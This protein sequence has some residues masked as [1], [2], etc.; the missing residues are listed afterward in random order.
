MKY[1][2]IFLFFLASCTTY[3]SNFGNKSGYSA[4]GFAYI[5]ENIIDDQKNDN[6]YISQNKLRVG[7]KIRIIN[8]SN[9]KFI[10]LKIKRKFKYDNFYKVLISKSV[11]EKLNLSLEF[12]FVEIHEIKI[13]KSF[14][15]KKATTNIEEKKI[16][17]KAPVEKININ[18]ISKDK[19]ILSKKAQTY[20]IL[21]AEFYN[22]D[23]AEF[24][25]EKLSLVLKDS[26]YH[27]IYINKKN[28]KNYQLFMGP[29]KTINKLKNDYIV[30]ADSNFEDLDIKIND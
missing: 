21:V 1:K 19:Q 25:K 8:P 29:Y 2:L 12:P 11:A 26:N 4:S 20:S 22:Y 18:N 5:D 10:E 17:S 14:V 16:A 6:F 3:S 23:S 15:A 7:N 9:D 28:K 13:N 24:L 30:L 27:L